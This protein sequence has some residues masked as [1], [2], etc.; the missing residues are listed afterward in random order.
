MTF[1]MSRISP[2]R[3]IACRAMRRSIFSGGTLAIRR[4]RTGVGAM[5]LTV[6]PYSASSRARIWVR[7]TTAAFDAA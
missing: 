2:K 6:I 7:A 5:A 3:G 4:V 1:V